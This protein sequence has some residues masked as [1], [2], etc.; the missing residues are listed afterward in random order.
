MELH[1]SD[2]AG[3]GVM[4]A[5]GALCICERSEDTKGVT[6]VKYLGNGNSKE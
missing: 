2:C 5:E 6:Y 1:M 3:N 4:E